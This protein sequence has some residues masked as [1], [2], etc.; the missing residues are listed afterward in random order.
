LAAGLGFG[1]DEVAVEP[2]KPLFGLADFEE[3]LA[4]V[5]GL[6]AIFEILRDKVITDHLVH[7][8][9]ISSR[10]FRSRA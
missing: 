8:P 6:G 9:Q 1:F 10:I 3:P 4:P 2:F 5:G 7:I